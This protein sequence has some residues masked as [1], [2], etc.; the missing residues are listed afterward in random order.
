MNSSLYFENVE[1]FGE[2]PILLSAG[3]QKD[4]RG[5]GQDK[6]MFQAA[7]KRIE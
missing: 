3:A 1:G 6:I 2:W 7:M 5:I 4:L